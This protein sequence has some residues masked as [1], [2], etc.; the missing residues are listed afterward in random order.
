MTFVLHNVVFSVVGFLNAFTFYWLPELYITF[1]VDL[2]D[3]A[4]WCLWS[5]DALAGF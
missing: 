2:L 4:F 3:I 5:S 1:A